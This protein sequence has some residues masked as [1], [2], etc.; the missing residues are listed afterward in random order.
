MPNATAPKESTPATAAKPTGHPF[1]LPTPVQWALCALVVVLMSAL[2]IQGR[3]TTKPQAEP[4]PL[5][6]QPLDLNQASRED[7]RLLPGI[8]EKLSQ[9]IVEYRRLRGGFRN[10]EEL[11]NV[12]GIGPVTLARLRNWV[13]V[14][15]SVLPSSSDVAGSSVAFDLAETAPKMSRA[16]TKVEDA[17]GIVVNINLA[18]ADELRKIPGIG[19]VLSQRIID[20]RQEKGP[21][22]SAEDLRRVKGIGKKTL[23]KMRPFITF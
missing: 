10:V 9:R 14:T 1:P 4:E 7:F 17:A 13:T 11:R 18:K 5:L 23:E 12:A 3:Q 19:P 6:L 21:F 16:R 22:Q 8:G 15:D 20:A 2:I